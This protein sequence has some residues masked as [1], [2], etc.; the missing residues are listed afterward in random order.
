[1]ITINKIITTEISKKY[2]GELGKPT[3]HFQPNANGIYMGT[4]TFPLLGPNRIL[5]GT[6]ILE[7][8]S[9]EWNDFWQAFNTVTF[10]IQQLIAKYD[11][12]D[13][14]IP[15]NIESWFLNN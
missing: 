14:E 12:T 13:V 2:E 1:M 9:A 3:I 7:Y 8:P 6:M 15:D 5:K 11:L 10:L 4:I